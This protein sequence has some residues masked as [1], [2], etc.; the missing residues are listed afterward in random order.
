MSTPTNNGPQ[1]PY[2][3]PA[4]P[5]PY[6]QPSAYPQQP[7]AY[8]Q[9]PPTYP[10]QQAYPQQPT[11]GQQQPAQNPYGQ[12]GYPAQPYGQMPPAPQA[13]F[14]ASAQT[15]PGMVTAAAVLAFVSG[16]LGLLL[17][18]VG[19]SLL[20]ALS[21]FFSFIFILIL[22]VSAVEIWGGIQVLNGKDARILTI[23]AAVGILLNLLSLVNSFQAQSLVSFVVP[24]LIIY[25]LMNPQAKAWFNAKGAKHF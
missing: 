9:Q 13:G 17:G 3:P 16:G 1:D 2:G 19:L 25:F 23:T 6:G 7:P 12:Q 8:P 10:Q 21:G 4:S 11:Y 24:I 20:S 14:G 15:R 5:N 22:I 18:L